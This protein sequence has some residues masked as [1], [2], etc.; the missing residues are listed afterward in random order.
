MNCQQ[1]KWTAQIRVGGRVKHL[2][3]FHD[4]QDAARAYD[5]AAVEC[6]G[7]GAKL[8]FNFLRESCT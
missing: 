8:N 7:A 6:L 3:V 5:A 2:G 4:D 1:A